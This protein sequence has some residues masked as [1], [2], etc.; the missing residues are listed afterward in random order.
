VLREDD[1]KKLIAA[2]AG[3]LGEKGG[4][5]DFYPAFLDGVKQG[6]GLKGKKL[7]FPLRAMLTGSLKGPELDLAAP[8]IGRE[9]CAR[10]ALLCRDRYVKP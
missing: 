5:G 3:L 4:G 9:K 8:L 6:T 7:F 2:A 10:R 1:G